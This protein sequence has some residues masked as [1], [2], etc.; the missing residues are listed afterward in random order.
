MKLVTCHERRHGRVMAK[1]TVSG[2]SVGA[3]GLGCMGMTWAYGKGET[4]RAEHIRVIHRALD[5]GADVI[6]TADVY[7]PFT[8]EE[9]VGE[10]LVGHR[11]RA[12]LATKVGLATAR[13]GFD[14]TRDGRPEHVRAAI[15]ASLRR[16]R[17]DV[18]DL[19]QL[20]RA[21]PAVPLEE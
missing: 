2:R 6:D 3:V 11:D 5:I 14:I 8:N 1:R 19:Y 10:A 4:E 12:F 15:D 7:G 18:V 17:V 9:L 13:E 21:D 16:L 20:H